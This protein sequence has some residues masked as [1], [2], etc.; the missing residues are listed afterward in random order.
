MNIPW[1]HIDKEL[2][3]LVKAMNY[4]GIF[5]TYSCCIGHNGNRQTEIIFDVIDEGHR[6]HA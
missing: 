6:P 4:S 3:P 1:E 5:K 2:I